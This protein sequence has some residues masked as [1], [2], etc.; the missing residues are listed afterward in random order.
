MCV[1]QNTNRIKQGKKINI[2][3]PNLSTVTQAWGH[4]FITKL[5]GY[6]F[7]QY[8][9]KLPGSNVIRSHSLWVVRRTP[10]ASESPLVSSAQ[11]LIRLRS[12]NSY[13]Y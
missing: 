2:Y 6:F 11:L 13:Y 7:F 12:P 8:K 1:N 3:F 5:Y 9:L 4:V 10:I